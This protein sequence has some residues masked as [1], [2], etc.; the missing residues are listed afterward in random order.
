MYV[1]IKSL[2]SASDLQNFS[3]PLKKND[4]AK[5]RCDLLIFFAFLRL[6]VVRRIG[7]AL[8]CVEQSAVYDDRSRRGFG[9]GLGEM[10][11]ALAQF[12]VV[13]IFVRSEATAS[14]AANPT[15]S[16]YPPQAKMNRFM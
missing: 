14:P 6:P 4:S 5:K 2:Y 11:K 16:C 12:R 8:E 9:I 1:L 7:S 10:N 13:V 15:Y 3:S